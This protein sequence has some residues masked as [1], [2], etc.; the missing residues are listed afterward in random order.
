MINQFIR[1]NRL[2]R[3]ARFFVTLV[4]LGLFFIP[5]A[6]AQQSEIHKDDQVQKALAIAI[7]EYDRQLG[8]NTMTYTGRSYYDPNRSVNGHQFF[9][10][11]YWERGNVTYDGNKYDSIFLKYDIYKDL[12]LIENFNS[13][14]FLSPI[15]LFSPKVTSFE[16]F[17]YSFKRIEKDTISNLKE[18][19][20][21][22]MYEEND[23]G[24]LIK[25]RKEI[26]DVNA[27]NTIVEEYSQKDK[28]YI[29]KDMTYHQVKKKNSILKVLVDH[30]K[31]M[32][33]FIKLKNYRFINHPDLQI[34]EIVKYYNSLL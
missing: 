4:L 18:G 14:G 13:D 7:D 6:S 12:L 1:S 24:V 26:T 33:S 25:R 11:D 23:M 28:Y 15:I 22:I 31:E 2:F 5:S 20:Y 17:G 3:Q 21:N 19:Y 16:L 8:R 30:K 27:T 9:V 10:E 29:K 32:K 34:V